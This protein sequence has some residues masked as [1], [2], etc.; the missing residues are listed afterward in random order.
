MA[1]ATMT[2]DPD[3]TALTPDEHVTAIN[4]ATTPITRASSVSAAARPIAAGEVTDTEMA[5]TA[6]RDNLKAMSDVSREVVLTRPLTGE[7]P[8]VALQRN[9]GGDVDVEY[10]DVVIP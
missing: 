10:D 4:A 2:I 3:A 5:A 8:I 6:A 7:F 1:I 9:A